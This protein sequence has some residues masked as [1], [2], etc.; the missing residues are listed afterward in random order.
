MDL[1]KT[2]KRVGYAFVPYQRMEKVYS[3]A[4]AIKAGTIFPELNIPMEDYQR[5][6]FNGK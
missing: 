6:L 5:G 2:P 1:T 3:P 4:K